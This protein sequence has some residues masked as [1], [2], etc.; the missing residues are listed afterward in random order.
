MRIEEDHPVEVINVKVDQ[1]NTGRYLL[2]AGIYEA[3]HMNKKSW[4][5]IIMDDT[6]SDK[7]IHGMIDDSYRSIQG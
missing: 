1:K 6:L 2:Q 4:V 5:S 3:Y 7:E